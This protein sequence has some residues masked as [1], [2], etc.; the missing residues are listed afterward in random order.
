MGKNKKNHDPIALFLIEARSRLLEIHDLWRLSKWRDLEL[1]A[2]RF[3]QASAAVGAETL[4]EI[5]IDIRRAAAQA[6]EELGPL[7]EDLFNHFALLESGMRFE[8]AA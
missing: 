2:Q 8:A 7:V 6:P 5:C 4:A 1:R 3:G